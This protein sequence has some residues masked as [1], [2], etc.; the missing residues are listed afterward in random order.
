[1][2]SK[3]LA[4]RV[5][6]VLSN[7]ID[8]RQT[9]HVNERFIGESGRLTDDAIKVCDIQ[10]IGGYLLTVDFEKAFDSLNHEFLIAV[11]KFYGFGEDFIDRIKILLRHQ[12]SCA[13]NGGHTTTYFHLER[14]AKQGDPISVYLF[15]LALELFFILIKSNKNIHGTN[16]FNHDFLY[17]AY[18]DD[19]TFFLKDFNSVKNVLEMLNQF[20]MVSGLRPNFSKCQIAGIGSL[21]H[22]KVALCGLKILDLTKESIKILGVYISYNTKLQNNINFCMTV[23]NICNVIKSWRM[24]HLSLEGNITIFKSLALSKIVYLTLLTI[25]PKQRT[26]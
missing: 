17:T 8:S 21:K 9:A 12:E 5:T 19:T 4:I 10:K 7:L 2:I 16:I 25:V 6:K 18:A 24:R 13:I 23:K 14:E 3:S 11:L 1:M 20:Y 22:A 15:V 26:E